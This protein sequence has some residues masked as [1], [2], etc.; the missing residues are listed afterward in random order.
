V[1]QAGVRRFT[2]FRK[3][4]TDPPDAG[5]RQPRIATGK[6]PGAFLAG[7][8]VSMFAR[9][10]KSALR[11]KLAAIAYLSSSG[12][13][14]CK[15]GGRFLHYTENISTPL[16]GVVTYDCRRRTPALATGPTDFQKTKTHRWTGG[17]PTQV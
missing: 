1:P 14:I 16:Q 3:S 2:F 11:E 10:E 5:I 13:R 12:M 17:I 8:I 9:D 7:V 4:V 15:P 6:Y